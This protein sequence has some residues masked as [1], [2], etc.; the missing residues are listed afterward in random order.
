M[1]WASAATD[2]ADLDAAL[3]AIAARTR[4]DLGDLAVDL[5]VVFVSN[6]FA[7]DYDRIPTALAARIPHRVLLG[8]SAGAVIGGGR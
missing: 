1:R 7:A 6:H 4:H 8:C 5:A 3:D 2:D